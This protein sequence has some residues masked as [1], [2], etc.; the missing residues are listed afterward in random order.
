LV[1]FCGA[2]DGSQGLLPDKQVL[3]SLL[4]LFFFL[5]VKVKKL[6]EGDSES[7]LSG[8]SGGDTAYQA[9]AVGVGSGRTEPT[10]GREW[11]PQD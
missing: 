3:Y 4:E 9:A 5:K 6:W 8:Q 10:R 1:C 7:R 11:G 2:G